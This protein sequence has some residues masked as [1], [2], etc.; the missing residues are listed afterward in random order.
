LRQFIQASINRLDVTAPTEGG[1]TERGGMT[2]SS[3][4]RD[5]AGPQ[6]GENNEVYFNI[7]RR[8]IERSIAAGRVRVRRFERLMIDE[9]SMLPGR[10]LDFVE[11]LFRQLSYT[12]TR[13]E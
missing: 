2:I 7:L 8:H 10:Q 11:D 4:L 13:P 9:G 6:P 1:G 5:D 3:V 12:A